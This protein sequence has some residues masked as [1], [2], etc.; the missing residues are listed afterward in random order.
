MRENNSF[1]YVRNNEEYQYSTAAPAIAPRRSNPNRQERPEQRKA[2]KRT[3]RF[4]FQG[5]VIVAAAFAFLAI[6]MVNYVRVQSELTSTRKAVASKQVALNNLTSDNDE[7]YSRIVNSV[8][9]D[10]I[11][12]IARG[13]LGMKYAGEGQII[14]YTSAGNDY[15][16][17][18]DSNN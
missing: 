14:T 2:K 9:L 3:G 15:M 5:M 1:R 11:E 7:L 18:V 6:V 16:R 13:E 12:A 10:Q 4:S 8:D 17:R